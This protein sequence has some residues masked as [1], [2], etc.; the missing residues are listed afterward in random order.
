MIQGEQIASDEIPERLEPMAGGQID[1][2][3]A[4]QEIVLYSAPG[5]SQ[6]G[7]QQAT[8][9]GQQ[10]QQQ[11]GQQAT[12]AMTADI[13]RAKVTEGDIQADNGTIHAISSV[14]VPPDMEQ[15]LRQTQGQQQQQ[16]QQ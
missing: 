14:L 1:V 15:V 13:E 8:A 2:S 10:G 4:G 6:Q 11:Q 9:G 16:G 5:V 12:G 3:L 7:Q